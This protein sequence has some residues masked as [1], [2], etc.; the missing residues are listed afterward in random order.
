MVRELAFK[1]AEREE[2]NLVLIDGSPGIGC[3]VIASITGTDLALIMTEPSVSGAHD[4]ER[5]LGVTEHFGVEPLVCVNKYDLNPK[6]TEEI[7]RFCRDLGVDL[8]G[9]LPFD[10]GVV[11]AMISGKTLIEVEGPVG[12]AIRSV[13]KRIKTKL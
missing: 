4:L 12:E 9:E 5:I 3:P 1:V 2:K 13:W 6:M 8:A 10:P 7:E 11:E